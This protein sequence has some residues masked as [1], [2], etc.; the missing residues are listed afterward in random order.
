MEIKKKHQKS[1]VKFPGVLMVKNPGD[2]RY[3]YVNISLL[4]LPDS[5]MIFSTQIEPILGSQ[6]LTQHISSNVHIL[7]LLK[8]CKKRKRFVLDFAITTLFP[9]FFAIILPIFCRLLFLIYI[10]DLNKTIQFSN[11]H[12]FA[13]DTY[14][15]GAI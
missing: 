11:V 3:I 1:Y 10:N 14:E 6:G 4:P 12:Y 13:E 2:Q 5:L 15:F 9:P 8:N 7:P